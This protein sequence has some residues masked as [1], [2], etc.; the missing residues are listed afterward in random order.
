M[1]QASSIAK[2]DLEHVL[3]HTGP[4]WEA[5]RGK[6][7]FLT[8]GTGFFGTWLL[9]SFAYINEKLALDAN[10]TILSRD[11]GK[12][13]KRIPHLAGRKDI[14][15][16]RGD[17]SDFVFPHGAFQFVVHAA[18]PTFLPNSIKE[19]IELFDTIVLGTR[20]VLEFAVQGGTK[21]LLFTS[22]G[23]VYGP[24]PTDIHN[25][26]ESYNGSPDTLNPMSAYGNAKRAAEQLCALFGQEYSINV[27]IARCFAFVGPA[28]RLDGH[29]AAGNFIRDGIRGGPIRVKSDGS[30]FRS[31]LYGADLA[32]WLWTMLFASSSIGVFNVGSNEAI[33]ISELAACVAVKFKCKIA[34]IEHSEATTAKSSGRYVPD[35]SKA[36]KEFNLSVRVPLD[37][38]IE[39]TA[40]WALL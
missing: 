32:V 35:I 6:A 33:S 13:S 26:S 36:Q 24:Q 9:E 23:A 3:T 40:K 38:A 18:A 37:E 27:S 11:P 10:I 1:S 28:L 30:S 19:Q 5:I 15:F 2:G 29:Y 20:R 21:N 39:R 8:G 22:S 14:S 16:L 34:Y 25:L 31:Y 12:F 4:Y 7:L 17:I